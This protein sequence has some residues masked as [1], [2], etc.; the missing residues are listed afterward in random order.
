MT[1]FRWTNCYADVQTSMHDK[2]ILAY[3]NDVIAPSIDTL[4][5]RV[6]ELNE[7]DDPLDMF[8]QSDTLDVLQET[9][10]AFALSIQSIWERQLRAYLTGCAKELRPT[11]NLKNKVEKANWDALQRI[12]RD[13]RGLT[14]DSFPSFALLDRLQ[15][16]G[17][18]CRH[19]DGNS[20]T[21]LHQLCPNLWKPTP[22]MPDGFGATSSEPPLVSLLDISL[23]HL[24][25]FTEAVAQFWD[26]T[27]YIYNE[28]IECKHPSLEAKLAFERKTRHWIPVGA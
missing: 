3:F 5:Q 21:R 10:L 24:R 16:L 28:S 7:S 23:E 20:A 9:K 15:H 12:F 27:T 11:E 6:A 8:I 18:A 22:S 2:T 14:L 26:D 19:G 1:P 13:L 25:Q 4:E 17:N